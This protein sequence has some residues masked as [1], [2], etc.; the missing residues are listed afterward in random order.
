[1]RLASKISI[2]RAKLGDKN[3]Q[4]YILI[5]LEQITIVLS[6]DFG[7]SPTGLRH[8]TI[9]MVPLVHHDLRS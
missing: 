1:M 6:K 4:L 8:S 5:S 2:G 9:E 7:S 3:D